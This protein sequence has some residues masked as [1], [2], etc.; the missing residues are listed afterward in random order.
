MNPLFVRVGNV[1][2]DEAPQALFVQR[3]HVVQQLTP[4]TS[5]PPFRDAVL[6]GCLEA[7]AFGFQTGGFQERDDIGAEL[8]V[9]VENDVTIRGCLWKRFTQ[10][11]DD[12]LRS[13]VAGQVEVQDLPTS[14][15]D[16]E[17]ALEQLKG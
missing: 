6:P 2:T 17:Q 3:D 12:P 9:A 13:W 11:L 1:I 5:D 8:R 15:F 4:A 14:V 7:R 16:D 10:L